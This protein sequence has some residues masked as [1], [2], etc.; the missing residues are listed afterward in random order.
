MKVRSILAVVVVLSVAAIFAPLPGRPLTAYGFTLIQVMRGVFAPGGPNTPIVVTGS[1][2]IMDSNTT[3]TSTGSGGAYQTTMAGPLTGIV[4]TS[5]NIPEQPKLKAPLTSTT[6]WTIHLITSDGGDSTIVGTAATAGGPVTQVV[7][8]PG[9]GASWTVS[10][11][12]ES[13]TFHPGKTRTDTISE[14]KVDSS[15]SQ[16]VTCE[17][18]AAIIHTK[19]PGRCIIRM[20][21]D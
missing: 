19:Q 14:V 16:S 18:V 21:T 17:T 9:S 8:T 10:G 15:S 3:W 4:V 5:R 12:L 20:H 2:I 13:L 11:D 7:A 6:A 1:S